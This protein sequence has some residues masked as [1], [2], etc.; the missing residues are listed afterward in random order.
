MLT[1]P[2]YKEMLGR[3]E[4]AVVREGKVTVE[5][6][7]LVTPYYLLNL[8]QGF[9]HGKDYA[10][11]LFREYGANEPG[12]MYRYKNEPTEINVLSSPVEAVIHNL[13]KKIDEDRNP[14]A[15]II[16]GVDELWDV[17]LMKFIY[18]VTRNSLHSNVMELGARR[19]L[20]VDPGGITRYTRYGIEQLFL[21]ARDERAKVYELE[22]ELRRWGLFEEYEDRFLDLFRRS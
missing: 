1:E 6:P 12:L 13:N 22:A 2:I 9:E 8:F 7:K 20:D 18:D 3:E 17:S 14:M 10:E 5:R 21:E 11:Y 16:R 15:A 19:L 4:E